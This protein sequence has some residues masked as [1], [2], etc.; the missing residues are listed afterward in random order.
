MGGGG[1]YCSANSIIVQR[2]NDKTDKQYQQLAKYG[3]A[4]RE[5]GKLNYRMKEGKE[6]KK[7]KAKR[8]ERGKR[9][10]ANE[11]SEAKRTSVATEGS[12]RKKHR[13]RRGTIIEFAPL[14]STHHLHQC[15]MLHSGA[16]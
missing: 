5:R 3:K 16:F 15:I 1:V 7:R 9:S 12:E 13:K 14:F 6:A 10:E 4:K 8:S 2:G 11:E